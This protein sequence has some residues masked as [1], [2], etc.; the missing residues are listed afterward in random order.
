[1]SLGL[2]LAIYL[3][4][5]LPGIATVI[6]I[7]VLLPLAPTDV[8]SKSDLSALLSSQ[9]VV[10]AGF[11]SVAYLLGLMSAIISRF[12]VDGLSEWL[13]RPLLL[14]WR[15]RTSYKQLQAV[16]QTLPD[17]R[18]H[19]RRAWNQAYRA[20]LK[21]ITANGPDKARD[22]VWR[23]REQGRL[24]RNLFVPMV[25]VS[26][27]STQWLH[28]DNVLWAAALIMSVSLFA[29]CSYSYAEYTTFAES[30]LHLPDQVTTNTARTP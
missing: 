27:A 13:S 10:T 7:I 2:D 8:Q 23:R 1:M 24:V 11:L 30:I 14:R 15:S 6:S 16:L 18:P 26:A 22:E 25:L 17:E 28:I 20:S 3:E 4:N 21:Y 19:W 5:L 12:I 29:V 9:F